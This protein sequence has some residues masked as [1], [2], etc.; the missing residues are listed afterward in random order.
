MSLVGTADGVT[1]S[2]TTAS[3]TYVD[4]PDMAVTIN[5]TSICT[6][7][8]W[9]TI[10]LQQTANTNDMN[11]ALNVDGGAAVAPITTRVGTNAG[12][13]AVTVFGVWT[14]VAA[15]AHTIRGRWNTSAGTMTAVG[16]SRHLL[17]Q[18]IAP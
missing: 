2:P 12:R 7:L 3:T 8:A 18:Q 11:I 15:G 1:S 13:T 14:N 5:P 16:V 9:L 4:I 6:L 10:S 17:V